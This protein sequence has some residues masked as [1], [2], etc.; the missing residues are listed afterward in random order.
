MSTL[1]MG[2]SS[3]IQNLCAGRSLAV[4][5]SLHSPSIP[6]DTSLFGPELPNHQIEEEVPQILR[7]ATACH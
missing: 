2:N 7:S 6:A 3:I 4:S 5:F 1:A